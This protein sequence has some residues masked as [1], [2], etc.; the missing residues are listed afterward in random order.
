MTDTSLKY[1]TEQN[2]LV[3]VSNGDT[4]PSGPGVVSVYVNGNRVENAANY[5]PYPHVL[6]P[7]GD[8]IIVQFSPD[9]PAT[10]DILC[11]SWEA[12]GWSYDSYSREQVTIGG[13]TWQ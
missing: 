12:N 1:P 3:A 6:V 4:C 13:V 7:P 9:A 10:T 5:V 8:C 11:K 2:G